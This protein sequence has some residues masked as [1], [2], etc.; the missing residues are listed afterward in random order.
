[1]EI[2]DIEE[3]LTKLPHKP[4]VYI[5]HDEN[6]AI[7]YVGK[8]I[9]LH[10]RVRQYFRSGHGHNNSPKI[11]RMVSQISYFEY[12]ITASE[13]EALVL[14]C[15]LIKEH[16]PKYNTLMTDDKGYPFIKVTVDEK[17]PRIMMSHRMSRDKSLYFGPFTDRKAVH[18][19]I[20]L[21]KKLFSIRNCNRDLNYG[22]YN[23][24]PCLYHHIGQCDSPCAGNI[25][26]EDYQK[27]IENVVSFLNGNTKDISNEL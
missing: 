11:L 20:A 10:N 2:F 13:M 14:E 12:I 3:E 5:M 16:R 22:P 9:D 17:F 8:A 1:M 15:N 26:A 23:E 25:S 27:K 19:T 21:V 4:G 18:D 24:R 6:E 7:L